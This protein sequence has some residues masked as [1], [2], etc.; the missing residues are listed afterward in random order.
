MQY[1]SQP[2][3]GAVKQKVGCSA[4]TVIRSILHEH[5]YKG[6][7]SDKLITLHKAAL[8]AQTL[9]IHP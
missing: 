5:C 8:F 7:R 6:L 2:T 9:Y 1:K 3:H 4:Q